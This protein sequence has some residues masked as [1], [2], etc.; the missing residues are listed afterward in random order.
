MFRSILMAGLLPLLVAS[1][2]AAQPPGATFP[3]TRYR[4]PASATVLSAA[5]TVLPTLAGIAIAAS[6]PESG[7]GALLF[8]GGLTLGP[9]MGYFST[10]RW[11]VSPSL[12]AIL[13]RE[14]APSSSWAA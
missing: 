11:P 14:P 1:Q 10:G 9:A 5:F 12:P 6:D 8:M 13:N 3:A 7:A 2:V 4:D